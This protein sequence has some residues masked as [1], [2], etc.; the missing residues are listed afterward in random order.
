MKT[1][2]ATVILIATLGFTN[3]HSQANNLTGSPYSLFGLGIE[4][5][6]NVG[7]NS[8]LGKS[9]VASD[10]YS[11]INIHNPALFAT[12][13]KKRFLFDVGFSAEIDKVSNGKDNE[14]RG[15]GNFSNIALAFNTNGKYGI[16]LT[17][18]PATD[19]GYALIGVETEVEGSEQSYISNVIGSGGLNTVRLDYGT[20]ILDSLNVGFNIS[21]LFGKID[22]NETVRINN[23]MLKITKENYY[24]G[25]QFGVGFQLKHNNYNWGLVVDAP[26]ILK[27]SKDTEI[28]K[29]SDSDYIIVENEYN[30]SIDDFILPLK[31]KL[32]VS[33]VYN[34]S[35]TLNLDYKRSFWDM[36]DQEDNIG[37]FSD[38]DVIA[39]GVEYTIDKYAF[40]YW[41]RIDFRAGYNYDSGYLRINDK[42]IQ[43]NSLS[44][45][46]G[47][48]IGFKNNNTINISYTYGK[49]GSTE[50]ILIEQNFNSI[51]LNISLSDIWFIKRKID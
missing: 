2:N 13:P 36:T 14:N 35:L 1:I 12:I 18:M 5:N 41:K 15:A 47:L 32:G 31:V 29:T 26:V 27:A 50:D 44:L 21:Y 24:R 23:S 42:K 4:T 16:G 34:K 33:A 51:N 28:N 40:N 19:V 38:Q 20:S 46:I 49:W 8:G 43:A 48:P 10:I 11:N 25:A 6:S 9:G 39:L 37:R 30:E 7:K 3:I 17:L 22:E 45:G